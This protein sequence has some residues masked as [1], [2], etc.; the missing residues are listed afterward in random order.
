MAFAIAVNIKKHGVM[1][2]F[3]GKGSQ[4]FSDVFNEEAYADLEIRLRDVMGGT[5]FI[6]SV[7]DPNKEFE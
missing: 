2:R 4:Y 3:G 1:K 5:N 6:L 7:I